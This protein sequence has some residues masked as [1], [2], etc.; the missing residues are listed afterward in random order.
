MSLPLLSGREIVKAMGAIGYE[1]DHQRGSHI[2]LRHK[3]P[4]YRRITVPDDREVARGTLHSIIKAAGVTD[5]EFSRLL[6]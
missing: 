6:E 2:V 3:D 1:F 4:P 5:Q